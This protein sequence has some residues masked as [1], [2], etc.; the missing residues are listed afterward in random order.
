MLSVHQ[1]EFEPTEEASLQGRWQEAVGRIRRFRSFVIVSTILVVAIGTPL[2]LSQMRKDQALG[3]LAFATVGCYVAIILWVYWREVRA[4][5]G[6]LAVLSDGVRGGHVRVTRCTSSGVV[7]LQEVED[8]GAAYFFEVEPRRLYFVSGQ[9]F[10]PTS[11][12]P[13][14]DFEIIEGFDAAGKPLLFEIRC[15]GS[16]I[17]P[18]R[19]IPSATK[20][21]LL[22]RSGYPQ[23]GDVIEGALDEIEDVLR[24]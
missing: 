7:G 3:M 9:E 14:D 15:H 19:T 21:E 5:R 16:R 23:D 22:E 4:T 1:R 8:E 2:A 6:W 10:Y 11:R 24:G 12:F 20:L 18:I 17:Q 13:N